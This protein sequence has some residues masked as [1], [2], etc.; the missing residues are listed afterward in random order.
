[1][2][3]MNVTVAKSN[4]SFNCKSWIDNRQVEPYIELLGIKFD[5]NLDHVMTQL[6]SLI[7]KAPKEDIE[8]N[9]HLKFAK[10][11]IYYQMN[12][13]EKAKILC[14]ELIYN[15]HLYYCEHTVGV[16]SIYTTILRGDNRYYHLL[17]AL[18][19]IQENLKGY[20][21]EYLYNTLANIYY[22]LEQYSLAI[23]NFK[24][25][26]GFINHKVGK[27]ASINNNIGLAYKHL[28]D[29]H[30]AKFH[31]K[32]ALD[33]WKTKPFKEIENKNDY[34]QFKEIIENNLLALD[35]NL[36]ENDMIFYQ[37][38]KQRYSRYLNDEKLNIFIDNRLLLDLAQQAFRIGNN[39]EADLFLEHVK[40]NIEDGKYILIEDKANYEFLSL[41]NL[42]IK[43]DNKGAIIQSDKYKLVSEELE[44]ERREL[45]TKTF[46]VDHKW[47]TESLIEKEK[48]IKFEVKIKVLMYLLVS[49]LIAFLLIVIF[50]Y[51]NHK[52]MHL[53]I[54]QQKRQIE[55]SLTNTEML[56]K[57][58]H[59]RVKNNLQLVTSIA[60]IE[61]EK[62]NEQFDFVNFEN[63]I[64]SLSLIHS[65][66]YTTEHISSVSTDIYLKDLMFN[67]HS[68]SLDGFKYELDIQDVHVSLETIIIFGLLIN[69]LVTNTIKHCIPKEREEKRIAIS[70]YNKADQ[71]CL[72][73]KDNGVVF[74][75]N[76][77]SD[78]NLGDSLIT[79]LIQNLRGQ[80]QIKYNTGYELSIHFNNL[81]II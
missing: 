42:I 39:E 38:L 46:P 35:S 77:H 74:N 69:E 14:E 6:N 47:K 33:L 50:G 66:L 15:P 11:L 17:K 54:Y 22:H 51:V 37:S 24:H 40:K 53:Q 18:V 26:L 67:L 63:R 73:Y 9:F 10:S 55:K 30:N 62:N 44:N 31:F 81:Q 75:T 19:Y 68:T 56:L 58:V 43:G 25:L 59:H 60:Y 79:L 23:L 65:L 1:M 49:I 2:F 57:E 41:Q 13:K 76:E 34:Y 12:E 71:W 36:K 4:H 72:N 70:F 28:K 20:P 61:Y 29:K 48:A 3:A 78:M 8:L 16:V 52:K 21:A 80:Y 64:I 7:T 27:T 5:E 32:L 45:Y